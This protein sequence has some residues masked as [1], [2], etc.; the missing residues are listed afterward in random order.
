MGVGRR[1]GEHFNECRVVLRPLYWNRSFWIS[2]I[3]ARMQLIWQSTWE[4][5]IWQ[6]LSLFNQKIVLLFAVMRNGFAMITA[7]TCC[8]GDQS[9]VRVGQASELELLRRG[10]PIHPLPW[11]DCAWPGYWGKAFIASPCWQTALAVCLSLLLNAFPPWFRL[12]FQARLLKASG[13]GKAPSLSGTQ[14][15]SIKS[16]TELNQGFNLVCTIDL[17]GILM[18]S[19]N[20]VSNI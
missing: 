20:S 11:A 8:N 2:T 7:H 14:F 4:P 3:V 12:E 19:Q 18:R 17:F 6:E 9:W 10:Q 13:V 16:R 1:G 5:K 15:P